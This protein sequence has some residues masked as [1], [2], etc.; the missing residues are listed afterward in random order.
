MAIGQLSILGLLW[1]KTL[2]HSGHSQVTSVQIMS[3]DPGAVFHR[4]Q[5]N[6]SEDNE[7]VVRVSQHNENPT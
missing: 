1:S 5:L 3:S 2:A 7:V 4:Q 6:P